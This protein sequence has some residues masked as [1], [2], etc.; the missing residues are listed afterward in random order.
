MPSRSG[1]RRSH[2]A[3][4]PSS[5]R[6][7]SQCRSRPTLP[8]AP[9]ARRLRWCR[10]ERRSWRGC[11]GSPHPDRAEPHDRN[12]PSSGM[13]RRHRP[14][15]QARPAS[16]Q[17]RPGLEKTQSVQRCDCRQRPSRRP[18]PGARPWDGRW[19]RVPRIRR[20]SR[21]RTAHVAAPSPFHPTIRR[22]AQS[23]T[24]GQSARLGRKPADMYSSRRAS[25]IAIVRA[26]S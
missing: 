13:R 23:G 4:R 17:S 21:R 16:L 9:E 10:H 18:A 19:R 20:L 26:N 7:G 24:L 22:L 2:A 8:P 1:C 3:R 14:C 11:R 5:A 15:R 6:R 12:P 25:W